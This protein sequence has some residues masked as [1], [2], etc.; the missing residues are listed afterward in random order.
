MNLPLATT[1]ALGSRPPAAVQAP[2]S[3]LLIDGSAY[4]S[5]EIF[6]RLFTTLISRA[7]CASLGVVDELEKVLLLEETLD[8]VSTGESSCD[9]HPLNMMLPK[10]STA[11]HPRRRFT[12]VCSSL[13]RQL[14]PAQRRLRRMNDH[15][16]P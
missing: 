9:P 6:S 3:P 8:V 10:A 13:P 16:Q 12:I 5:S 7:A 14:L 1:R 4:C 15:L 11:T 2:N